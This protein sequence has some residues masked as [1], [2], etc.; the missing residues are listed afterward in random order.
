M[1]I[2]ILITGP[3]ISE[4][5][6]TFKSY[7]E[8]FEKWLKPFMPT[9]CQFNY[10]EVYLN[11]PLPDSDQF[12]GYLITGSR[13]AAYED[14]RWRKT[15]EQLILDI[16]Q[17]NIPLFGVCFGHQ[18]IAQA[19]G[20]KVQKSSKGWGVGSQIY[21]T[22]HHNSLPLQQ[23]YYVFHQDQITQM[24]ASATCLAGNDFCPYAVLQYGSYTYSVQFH[25][26]FSTWYF[27]ALIKKY[28]NT[29]FDAHRLKYATALPQSDNMGR[30]V[31]KFLQQG[32]H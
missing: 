27:D 18:I 5:Q 31:A 30:W 12:D 19:L 14:H 4:V 10:I 16:H 11:Q 3:I 25:P 23:P 9:H 6:D 21:Q 17:R 32:S 29:S 7:G 20:G 22:K 26:E 13:Y 24:P 15:L 1:H 28:C 2:A 8:K